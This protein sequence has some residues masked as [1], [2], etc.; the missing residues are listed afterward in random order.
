MNYARLVL[1]AVAATI[2]DALY[3]F[4]VWGRVLNGEFGRYPDIFRSAADQPAYLP[5]MFV[6]VLVG[7]IFASWIYAKGYEGRGGAAEGFRFGALLGL[8]FAAYMSGV[9]YGLMRIGKRLAL[10]YGVGWFGEWL[11]VGIVIGLVYKPAAG[12]VGRAAGV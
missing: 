10:T 5:L 11:V 6:G 2:V 7:M 3:G 12:G 4:L 9:N 8:L 1:A